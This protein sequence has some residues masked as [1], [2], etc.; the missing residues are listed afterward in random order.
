MRG[1]TI[2][3]K[4]LAGT[5]TMLDSNADFCDLCMETLVRALPNNTAAA[6]GVRG[7]PGPKERSRHGASSSGHHSQKSSSLGQE[8]LGLG[9]GDYSQ[10]V[11]MASSQPRTTGQGGSTQLQYLTSVPQGDMIP[12]PGEEPKEVI[13]LTSGESA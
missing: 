2:G 7:R 5:A 1:G 9:G 8:T 11:A 10:G 3:L 4:R 6:E 12:E 13:Y